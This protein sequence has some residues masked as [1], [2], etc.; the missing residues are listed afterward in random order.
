LLTVLSASACGEKKEPTDDVDGMATTEPTLSASVTASTTASM[1]TGPTTSSAPTATTPASSSTQPLPLPTPSMTMGTPSATDTGTAPPATTSAPT[2]SIS[3]TGTSEENGEAG[4]P[5]VPTESTTGGAGGGGEMTDAGGPMGG[6]GGSGEM[7]PAGEFSLTIGAYTSHDNAD[8][9]HEGCEPCELFT[10]QNVGVCMGDDES[11]EISWTAGP[12]GTLSYAVALTDMS[13]AM[14]FNH[15]AIWNIPA[16]VTS[17]PANL[18]DML[19]GELDGAV[20]GSFSGGVYAGPGACEH[21]YE[22]RVYAVAEALTETNRDAVLAALDS[23][24]VPQSFVR[25]R[26]KCTEGCTNPF[27]DR[28]CAAP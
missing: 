2:A 9:S 26:S 6:A 20:Q 3:A 15:W 27:P 23:E 10:P 7:P 28:L 13:L 22:F 25:L 17:L 4:A 21:V 19:S 14:P 1:P 24:E 16:S 11:P 5:A 12:E 18:G 8:C